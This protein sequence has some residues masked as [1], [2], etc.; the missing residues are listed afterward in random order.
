MAGWR[1]PDPADQKK[2]PIIVTRYNL[3]SILI[4]LRH[5]FAEVLL[6]LHRSAVSN[7]KGSDSG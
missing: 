5:R 7:V 1:W 3:C 6:L 2:G 4:G